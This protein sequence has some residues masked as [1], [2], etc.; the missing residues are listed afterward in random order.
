MR[1][2]KDMIALHKDIDGR[3]ITVSMNSID[4]VMMLDFISKYYKYIPIEDDSDI[5]DRLVGVI[6]E[7]VMDTSNECYLITHLIRDELVVLRNIGCDLDGKLYLGKTIMMDK[8]GE[9]FLTMENVGTFA[10]FMCSNRNKDMRSIYLKIYKRSL[11]SKLANVVRMLNDNL[12]E[13]QD[14]DTHSETDSECK[15]KDTSDE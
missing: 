11:E 8:S 5:Q 13:S 1:T 6:G 3:D 14:T 12:T 4:F 15:D 2:L 7:M 10:E 9:D